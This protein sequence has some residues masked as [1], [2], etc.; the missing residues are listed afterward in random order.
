MDVIRETKSTR[1]TTKRKGIAAV[2]GLGVVVVVSLLWGIGPALPAVPADSVLVDTVKRGEMIRKVSGPGVLVAV[3]TRLI[4]SIL[5]KAQVE[6][7][8]IQPGAVV[9]P[10]SV[11]L[12]LSNPLVMQQHDEAQFRLELAYAELQALRHQLNDNRL[13]QESKVAAARSSYEAAKLQAEREGKLTKDQIISE[14]QFRKSV[15]MEEQ[16]K[17]QQDVE[18]KR[19][20]AIPQLNA[21]EVRAKMAQLSLLKRQMD[22]QRNLVDSLEVKAGIDGVVQEIRVKEG[23]GVDQGE[24]LALVARQDQL[25]AEIRVI[26]SQA[27]EVVIGQKVVIDAGSGSEMGTVTRIDPSVINGAVVVDVAFN[28]SLP[29]GARANLRVNATIEIEKLDDVLYVGKP[30]QSQE[31][32]QVNL[33][34]VNDSGVATLTPVKLG[35]SSATT[36][37]ILGGLAEGDR[38]VLSD[39]SELAGAEEFKLK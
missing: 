37:E 23:Q 26:E 3:E 39:V 33:Y 20:R 35:R 29:K 2:V 17:T 21:S 9:T 16:F 31:H 8:L 6:R 27:K 14:V 10:D 24:I 5:P 22:L 15:L 34:K 28:G 19:L 13:N 36:V 30:A 4:P 25:K 11:L 7:I 18:L 32:A 1:W 38:V 12:R